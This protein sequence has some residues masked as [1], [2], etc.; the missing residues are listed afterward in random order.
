MTL[1]RLHPGTEGTN[2]RIRVITL[3]D[4]ESPNALNLAPDS[5]YQISVTYHGEEMVSLGQRKFRARKYQVSFG[6]ATI[7]LTESGLLLSS[8][9][10]TGGKIELVECKQYES[11]VPEFAVV[12]K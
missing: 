3:S 11:F 6:K 2:V 10:G 5:D 12:H 4:E 9:W 7:W 1:A 8:R